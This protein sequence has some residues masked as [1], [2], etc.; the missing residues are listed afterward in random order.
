MDDTNNINSVL[1]ESAV[2]VTMERGMQINAPNQRADFIFPF[3]SESVEEFTREGDD[4]IILLN[5]GQTIVIADFYVQAGEHALI[6]QTSEGP[7]AFPWLA[8]AGG[9]AAAAGVAAAVGGGGDGGS[10]AIATVDDADSTQVINGMTPP[11][12]FDVSGTGEPGDTVSVT[13]DGKTIDGVIGENGVWS[14][15]FEGTE[16]PGDGVWETSVVVDHAGGGSTTLDGPDFTIDT[17]GPALA[18]T[19]GVQATDDVFNLEELEGGATISGTGEVGASVSATIDGET[20]T[21]I[22]GEDGIWTVVWPVG[23]FVAGQ[24]T[25]PMIVVATDAAGNTTPVNAIV[26]TD[27]EAPE[28]PVVVGSAR[29]EGGLNRITIKSTADDTFFAQVDDDGVI[30]NFAVKPDVT[31]TVFNFDAELPTGSDLIIYAKDNAGNSSGTYLVVDD[32]KAGSDVDMSHSSLG[33]FQ[34]ETV[35][36]GRAEEAHLTITEAQLVGLADFSDTLTVRGGS[37][38]T[39]TIIGASKT[40]SE[41]VDGHTYDIYSFGDDATVRIEDDILEVNTSVVG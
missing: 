35:D 15:T 21:T 10:L 20:Q 28:S 41:T 30:T 14:V 25:T 38:D 40:G 9:I 27:M 1:R 31:K 12:S 6:F 39:V 26:Q 5:D 8:I 13:V 2:D 23:T 33:D 4:L 18:I 32:K 22:V 24:D 16:F 37:D 7:V 19:S 11:N 34:I 17:V 3:G 29:G 36:L